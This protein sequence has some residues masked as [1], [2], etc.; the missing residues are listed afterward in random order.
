MKLIDANVL[1]QKNNLAVLTPEE[2]ILKLYDV[3]IE[4]C[5]NRDSEKV[6]KVLHELIASLDF[7]YYETANTFHNVYKHA[8][9][10]L[11]RGDFPEIEKT[12]T[13]LRDAWDSFVTAKHTTT[14][15]QLNC[16][17]C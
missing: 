16:G 3:G 12:L 2:L 11:N 17:A 1:N 10:I 6:L 7:N 14:Q 13:E 8:I 4:S 15:E 9:L 5:K